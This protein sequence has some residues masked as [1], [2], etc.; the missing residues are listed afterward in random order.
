M[1][2]SLLIEAPQIFCKF[3]PYLILTIL[4]IQRSVWFL[5]NHKTRAIP[6]QH[7]FAL[8]KSLV[9]IFLE[10][11]IFSSQLYANFFQQQ[12]SEVSLDP[13][14]G[15]NSSFCGPTKSLGRDL[16]NIKPQW[17]ITI[18]LS[19]WLLLISY[20]KSNMKPGRQ[21]RKTQLQDILFL[22]IFSIYYGDLLLIIWVIHFIA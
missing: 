10:Y 6:T 2:S 3:H 22:P 18:I 21:C 16:E 19:V 17:Q 20:V 15:R 13:E 11:F 1:F 5:V 12:C 14:Y 9:T 4:L 8:Q 7:I